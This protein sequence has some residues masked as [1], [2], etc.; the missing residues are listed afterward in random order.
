MATNNSI[1]NTVTASNSGATSQLSAVN[2][3]NTASSDANLLSQ[4]GGSSG[5]DAKHQAVVNGVTT[6]TWGIDNSVTSPTA[7]PW[8]LSQGTT[9]GTNNVMSVA[10]SG[11]IN[12]PLQPAFLA[13]N[14]SDQANVTGDGTIYTCIYGTE[15]FDQNSDFASNT[16]TAPVTGKYQL[17]CSIGQ[18]NVQSNHIV[19]QNIISTSNRNYCFG[20]FSPTNFKNTFD[21]TLFIGGSFLCDMDA[22][23]TAQVTMSVSGGSKVVTYQGSTGASLTSPPYFSGFLAC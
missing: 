16:F 7:D 11:E 5:G 17:S 9:L 22:A 14:T 1:N 8:V 12:Y 23:D 3:S 13:S 10:T 15:I 6:W 21:S 18:G 19:T 2:S 4:V 20:R